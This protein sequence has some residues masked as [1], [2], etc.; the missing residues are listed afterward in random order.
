PW[1]K[2]CDWAGL[3]PT[4]HFAPIH[5]YSRRCSQRLSVQASLPEEGNKRWRADGESIINGDRVRSSPK[6]QILNGGRAHLML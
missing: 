6:R 5:W 4:A 2:R 1:L 3:M